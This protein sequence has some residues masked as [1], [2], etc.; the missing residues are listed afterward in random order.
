MGFLRGM[1]NGSPA[2]GRPF[3][4]A[5]RVDV[6]GG[7]DLGPFAHAQ[8]VHHGVAHRAVAAQAVVADDTVLA[9]AQAFDGALAG[10]VE[11]VGAPA[12]QLR[13]QGL[14]GVLQQE[15]LGRGVDGAALA[16]GRV[17]GVADLQP[18]NGRHDVVKTAC[19]R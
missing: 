1:V 2:G 14:E 19:C 15:Q 12:H 13:T 18:I 17:P 7:P 11:V 16:A 5:W 6:P 3:S 10:E 8:A 9:R 4:A